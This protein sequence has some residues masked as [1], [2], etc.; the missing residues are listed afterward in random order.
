VSVDTVQERKHLV[1][2]TAGHSSA[3]LARYLLAR[4]VLFISLPIETRKALMVGEPCETVLASD[5]PGALGEAL[6]RRD[7]RFS[8]WG[9]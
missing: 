9:G 3:N 7:G 2:T 8:L 6:A 1:G 5:V 4:I